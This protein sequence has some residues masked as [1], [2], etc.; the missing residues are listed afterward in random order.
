[1]ENTPPLPNL[2]TQTKSCDKGTITLDILILQVAQ[3]TSSLTDQHQQTSAGMMI[4]LVYFQMLGELG[5]AL[6]KKRDLYLG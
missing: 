5:D 1:M 2:F 4:F 3:E 6:G